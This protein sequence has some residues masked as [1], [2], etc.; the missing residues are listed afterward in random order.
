MN[1][2]RK[3]IDLTIE[4]TDYQVS[5][6][7]MDWSDRRAVRRSRTLVSCGNS[8]EPAMPMPAY[9]IKGE[10]PENDAAWRKYN[11]EELRLMRA[12]V[13]PVVKAEFPELGKLSFS[14]TAGCSCGCSPAF[15]AEGMVIDEEIGRVS[16][17]TITRK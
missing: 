5:M 12:I 16:W 13:D 4:G 14:R 1:A 17:I 8:V 3:T 10:D 2:K 6:I 15:R 9:S 7:G 11:R